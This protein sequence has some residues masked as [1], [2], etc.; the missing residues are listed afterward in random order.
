MFIVFDDRPSDS[1]FVERVWRC[2]SERAGT[3]HSMAA[4]HWEMVVTRHQGKAFL[5][6][7]G[8]E[9]KATTADCPAEG[10]WVAIRFKLGTFMPLLPARDLR[11]RT[12]VTLPEA[13]GRSFWLN[14]SAWEYPNFENAETF[15]K[16]LVQAGLIAVD[17]TV[18][19]ALQGQ[20]RELSLRSAQRHFLQATGIT[21]SAIRQI[22][23]ARRATNLLKQGVSILDTVHQAGYF[24]QAH[25]TRSLKYLI[26]QTPAQI[27]RA[28]E[29][30]S[31]LYKTGFS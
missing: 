30:L 12:D 13:T 25:L 8:P 10:E 14:G 29:Q 17:L 5:T 3:F 1:P 4:S 22:E 27:I 18:D 28:E 24:D 23:R 11:D 9:T 26:G 2:H 31:F 7:R 21:H 16:R 19:S 15:V 20:P 6:V